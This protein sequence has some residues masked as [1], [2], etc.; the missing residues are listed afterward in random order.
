MKAKRLVE[1]A[2]G[3]LAS[4]V[5]WLIC[6]FVAIYCL[7]YVFDA[8]ARYLR[9]QSCLW[10][11][12][13]KTVDEPYLARFCYLTKDTVLL[14]VYDITNRHLLAERIFFN[15]DRP[16]FYWDNNA[17]GYDTAPD[18]G[19]ISLPPTLLDRVRAKLP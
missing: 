19:L 9:G 11:Q 8:R 15:M 6:L 4:V 5:K 1:K 2:G 14:R 10:N 17:L 13:P 18:G 16:N 12:V 7:G 3:I